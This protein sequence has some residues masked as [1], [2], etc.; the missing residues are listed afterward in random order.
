MTDAFRCDFCGEYH[1]GK[2]AES[3]YIKEHAKGQSSPSY[4]EKYHLCEGCEADI[5]GGVP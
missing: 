2:P 4:H 5:N 1:D 3:L